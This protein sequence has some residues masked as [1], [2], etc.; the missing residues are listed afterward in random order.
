M[1]RV[2]SFTIDIEFNHTAELI[3]MLQ[4]LKQL[5]LDPQAATKEDVRKLTLLPK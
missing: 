4:K 1:N 5:G 2:I 3:I